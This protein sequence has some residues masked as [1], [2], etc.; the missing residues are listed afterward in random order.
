MT[1]TLD[2]NQLWLCISFR[3]WDWLLSSH[4][5]PWWPRLGWAGMCSC[6]CECMCVCA[7]TCMWVHVKTWDEPCVILRSCLPCFLTQGLFTE[8][9]GL[10]MR[11]EWLASELVGSGYLCPILF[12]VVHVNHHVQLLWR[13]WRSE[14]GSSRLFRQHWTHWA[15]SPALKVLL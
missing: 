11:L 4:V 14:L 6:M 7:C 13:C 10:P 1:F 12:H 15:N 8:T 3:W 5:S 2:P 9:W